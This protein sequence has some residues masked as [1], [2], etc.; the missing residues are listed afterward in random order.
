M[1]RRH[2]NGQK[3]KEQNDLQNTTQKIEDWVTRTPLKTGGNSDAL[4]S[5][6][7]NID[8]FQWELS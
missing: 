7:K 6:C 8:W 1:S 5:T 3:E 4:E 2:Y